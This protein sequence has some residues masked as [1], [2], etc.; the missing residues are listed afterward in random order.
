MLAL[1]ALVLAFCLVVAGAML[2]SPALGLVVAGVLLGAGAL[3]TDFD[4]KGGQ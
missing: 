1:A 3:L 4:R 2:A